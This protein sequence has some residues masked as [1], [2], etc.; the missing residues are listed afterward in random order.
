M[1]F[2]LSLYNNHKQMVYSKFHFQL[3][4]IKFIESSTSIEWDG[5]N[6]I[7]LDNEYMTFELT[8]RDKQVVFEIEFNLSASCDWEYESGDYYTPDEYYQT[9]LDIDVTIN[10]II[11]ESDIDLD[12]K[13]KEVYSLLEKLVL[14]K[15]DL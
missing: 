15:I 1:I 3:G 6:S 5:E 8:L 14:S 10:G 13:D 2:Y 9:N 12:L 11:S 7:S 4:K